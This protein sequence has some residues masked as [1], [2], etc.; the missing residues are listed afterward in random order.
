MKII[1]DHKIPFLS[2]V[3]EPY[4]QVTYLPGSSIHSR[5]VEDQ[6]ALIVRTRTLCNESLL[7][8]S[9]VK[10]IGTATIGFDHIDTRYCETMGIEW[11]NAPGCNAD[12]VEQYVTAALLH[13][14]NQ[15][16]IPL[17]TQTIGIV[18]VGNVG[19]RVARSSE[20]LGMRVL[21]NDPPRA[22]K[23]QTSTFV[24]LDALIR[25]A[26][27]ISLHV[28]LNREGLDQTYHLVDDAFLDR[29]KPGVLILNTCRGEVAETKALL[30]AIRKKQIQAPI[31]DCWEHEP[32]IN[33]ELLQGSFLATP[34]IAGYSQDGKANGTSQI[35][36]ALAKKFQLALT[37]WRP[38]SL[39]LPQEPD[40]VLAAGNQKLQ[41]ALAQA[42]HHSYPIWKD[43]QKLKK[44]PTT[45]EEQRSEYPV[46]REYQAYRVMGAVA[47]EVREV[48]GEM[49]FQIRL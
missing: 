7:K 34:H 10:F 30:K 19:S 33:T 35:V 49:G 18:G 13:W 8:H 24:E 44:N 38:E 26:D 22:R 47:E 16:A 43:S 23:E 42:V 28:P 4:A 32:H 48:L 9:R 29:C 20:R 14:A 5:D 12:S 31:I 40:I 45:F 41:S 3:L 21:L 37:N 25:E 6:D 11:I 27:I 2:G 15:Y 39:T 36:Q 1:A 46:R 17:N